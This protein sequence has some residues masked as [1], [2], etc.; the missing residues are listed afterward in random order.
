[1]GLQY[2]PALKG[3]RNSGLPAP[4]HSSGPAEV[5]VDGEFLPLF[6]SP[7]GPAHAVPVRGTQEAP[8]AFGDTKRALARVTMLAHPLPAAPIALTTDASDY[9]VGGQRLAAA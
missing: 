5:F 4:S 2:I 9:A 1:M 3:G 7:C 8:A 6:C